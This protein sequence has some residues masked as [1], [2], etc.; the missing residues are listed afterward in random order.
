MTLDDLRRN[1]NLLFWV[2][3]TVGWSAYVIVQ[4]VGALLYD[5]PG[6]YIKVLLIAGVSGFLLTI[7]LQYLYRWMWTR[8]PV[9]ILILVPFAAMA[10][11]SA[12]MRSW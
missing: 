11:P 5:K 6:S 3:Q 12:A 9:T 1:R 8:Q 10:A 4:Y 2:L 7:P